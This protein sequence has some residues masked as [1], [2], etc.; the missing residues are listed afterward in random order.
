[1]KWPLDVQD[2]EDTILTD[3]GEIISL[4]SNADYCNKERLLTTLQAHQEMLE[5]GL[6]YFNIALKKAV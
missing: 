5:F 2:L 4:S 1:M 6:Q 3:E